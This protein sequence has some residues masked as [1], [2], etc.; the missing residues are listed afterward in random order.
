MSTLYRK[1]P[2][3]IE[4]VRFGYQGWDF[5]KTLEWCPA[6][7]RTE[8]DNGVGDCYWIRTLEV[9]YPV[10]KGEFI[11]KGIAGEF[12]PCQPDIFNLTYEAV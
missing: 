7:Y 3:V 4:A 2:V 6:L 9:D 12:Y 1:K 5:G 8:D 11:I 10:H